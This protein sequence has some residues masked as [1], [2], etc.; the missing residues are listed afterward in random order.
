M[1]YVL[2]E[3][4]IRGAEMKLVIVLLSLAALGLALAIAAAGPGTQYGFWEYTFGLQILFKAALP[5]LIASG[6]AAIAFLVSL[7]AARGLAP[8]ALI[9][10]IAAGAAGM[11]PL[12]MKELVDAN[13][14]IHDITTDFEN[15]PAILTAADLPRAN[16]AAYAG[17]EPAPRSELTTAQAQQAAFPDIMPKSVN[18]G[19]DE[20][21]ETVRKIVLDMKMEILS[22]GPAE[23]GWV[24]EAT[25]TSTWF[26]FVDDFI[27]RLAPE[28]SMT[29][30]DVR[31]KSRVGG[32]DL[33][34]NARRVQ[35][36][37]VRLENEVV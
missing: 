16:P 11:I 9:A 6:A 4:K 23:A 24:V 2:T 19:V 33:G 3:F 35:E 31:S 32:S 25:Y 5:V 30:I 13:P 27:V 8:L 10:A 21:A 18:G 15:P 20:T 26:G 28:G 29:R 17:A 12:K 14:F 1:C 22:E 7:F 34:A 37:F 36:F